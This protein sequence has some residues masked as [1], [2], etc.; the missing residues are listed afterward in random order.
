ME[1][2]GHP[3]RRLPIPHLCRRAGRILASVF[4]RHLDHQEK[5]RKRRI[6]PGQDFSEERSGNLH[7]SQARWRS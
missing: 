7:S 6:H 5:A 2:G 4:P 3:G 1:T